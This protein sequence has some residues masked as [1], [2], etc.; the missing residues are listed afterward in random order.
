MKEKELTDKKINKNLQ[1][2]SNMINKTE[3][4]VSELYIQQ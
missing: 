1:D 3:L 4:I 2:L